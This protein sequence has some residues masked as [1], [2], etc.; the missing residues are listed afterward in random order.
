MS[1]GTND[2]L[3]NYY[4]MPE[5]RS[6]FTIEEYQSFLIGISE[7]FITD[8]HHLG[9]RK[10]D[11]TGVPPMGCLPLERAMNLMSGS[12]CNE[13]Y[14]KVSRDFNMKLQGLAD[15]LNRTLPGMRI[16]YGNVY[17]IVHQVV[18][19]PSSYGELHGRTNVAHKTLYRMN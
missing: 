1:L 18:Q 15:K 6:Q 5:R 2:F 9:A 11:L 12:S 10:L 4:T 7:H 8:L 17:D 14:N 13:E 3:E 16:A 19:N